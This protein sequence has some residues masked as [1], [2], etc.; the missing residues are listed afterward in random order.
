ME[1][2]YT[3][4]TYFDHCSVYYNGNNY[5]YQELKD[6]LKKKGKLYIKKNK[7]KSNPIVVD[8]H[9]EK[10]EKSNLSD[11]QLNSFFLNKKTAEF[12]NFLNSQ[13][14]L[15]RKG[16][17]AQEKVDKLNEFGMLWNP[18][19]DKWEIL[20]DKF[21][22]KFILKTIADSFNE[23]GNHWGKL[24]E[25]NDLE[26]WK[27]EQRMLFKIGDLSNENLVRL[28][29]INFP[30][31]LEPNEKEDL[32]IHRL[33]TL[34]NYLTLL[35]RELG[36]G[37]SF[38]REFCNR[39]A[40]EKKYRYTG[41]KILI[42]ESII[43]KKNKL[44]GRVV[45][46]NIKK[47]EETN[48]KSKKKKKIYFSKK[49]LKAIELLKTIPLQDFKK[50]IDNISKKYYPTWNDKN[51]YDKKMSAE[52]RLAE[53]LFNKNFQKCEKL[54]HFLSNNYYHKKERTWLKFEFDDEIKRYASEKILLIL[55]E[56]LLNTGQLNYSKRFRA[57]SF[58]LNYY[59]KEKNLNELL[60]LDDFIK[61][62]QIMTLIYRERIDKVI[63]KIKY[64]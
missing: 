18:K 48:T 52:E 28:K 27:G 54:Y 8:N 11:K 5:T 64:I 38:R 56:R 20:Y 43:I 44:K 24:R 33:V 15:R 59:K 51:I 40:L 62:H 1:I 42:N 55:D 22:N 30:F 26:V 17:L 31:D 47:V 13:R 25:L 35:N 16:K 6:L 21:K 41:A 58:L 37:S 34:F 9:Y 60:K 49:E 4:H 10:F 36:S 57:V 46:K 50:E 23:Y 14:S 53:L 12:K 7:I 29:F 45:L 19:D 32:S 61:K 63:S 2:V 39:Y 3:I